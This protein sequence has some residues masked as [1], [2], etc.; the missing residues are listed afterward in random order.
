MRTLRKNQPK[1]TNNLNSRSRKLKHNLMIVVMRVSTTPNLITKANPSSGN[2]ISKKK[3]RII[4]T[5]KKKF[6]KM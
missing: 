4:E 5:K 3:K 2:T 6:K 1:D